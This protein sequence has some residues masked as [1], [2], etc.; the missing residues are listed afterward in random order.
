MQSL[1]PSSRQ[2][3]KSDLKI[4]HESDKTAILEKLDLHRTSVKQSSGW[5]SGRQQQNNTYSS[6]SFQNVRQL[7][8]QEKM[9]EMSVLPNGLSESEDD[10]E[11]D[12]LM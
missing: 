9:K 12:K 7:K 10:E 11:M 3:F 8:V 6:T 5:V 1:I 2:Q 4:V